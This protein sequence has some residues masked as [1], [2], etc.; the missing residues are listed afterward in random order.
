M[1]TTFWDKG[2]WDSFT[3]VK[4]AEN[5]KSMIDSMGDRAYNAPPLRLG[6]GVREEK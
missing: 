5:H 1:P 4:T 2:R 6:N 3:G